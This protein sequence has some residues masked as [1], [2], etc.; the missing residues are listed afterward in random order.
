ML[1][2]IALFEEMEIT[3]LESI[4]SQQSAKKTPLLMVFCPVKSEI[5][6]DIILDRRY[7]FI[8]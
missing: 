6:G 7:F 4:D 3:Q 8:T 5:F 1:S 2:H